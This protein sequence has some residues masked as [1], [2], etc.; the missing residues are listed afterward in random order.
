MGVENGLLWRHKR[1]VPEV[2]G[3]GNT[4]KCVS[5][6]ILLYYSMS[7]GLKKKLA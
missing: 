3:L 5:R 7:M 6:V 2:D 4:G 1:I